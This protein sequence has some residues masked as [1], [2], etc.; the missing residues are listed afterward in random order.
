MGLAFDAH[1]QKGLI[2]IIV[3]LNKSS[4][5]KVLIIGLKLNFP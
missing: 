3:I 5:T 4:Q 2:I 1:L